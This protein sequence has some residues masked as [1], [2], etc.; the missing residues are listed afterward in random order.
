MVGK[1][2]LVQPYKPWLWF[3]LG[4]IL[5]IFIYLRGERGRIPICWLPPQ[6]PRM[7]RAKCCSQKS[8]TQ[9]DSSHRCQGP[10]YLN[11]Y[12]LPLRV[13]TSKK[14]ASGDRC[15]LRCRQLDYKCLSLMKCLRHSLGFDFPRF[16]PLLLLKLFNFLLHFFLFASYGLDHWHGIAQL[17]LQIQTTCYKVARGLRVTTQ[18]LLRHKLLYILIKWTNNKWKIYS[19]VACNQSFKTE[20]QTS[21]LSMT[22]SNWP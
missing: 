2:F 18:Y 21:Y 15:D 4:W 9:S 1:V 3:C 22:I 16:S 5:Y 10:S 11:H 17:L 13:C 6:T 14:L 12:L 7:A 8:E 20:K 19:N